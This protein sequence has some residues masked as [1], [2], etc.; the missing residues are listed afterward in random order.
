MKYSEYSNM[1]SEIE[2]I[3]KKYSLT[4]NG[5]AAQLDDSYENETAID[6]S[7]GSAPI[8]LGVTDV[9]HLKEILEAN[10]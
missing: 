9:D 5:I 2:N 8:E 3:L 4:I 10:Q 1:M 7:I 6:I